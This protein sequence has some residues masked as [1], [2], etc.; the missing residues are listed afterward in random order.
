MPVSVRKQP[1][2]RLTRQK[3]Y[4]GGLS[5]SI[6]EEISYAPHFTFALILT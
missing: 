5:L 4:H 3:A 6:P 2:R 1:Y